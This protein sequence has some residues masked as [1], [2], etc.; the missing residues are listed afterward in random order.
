PADGD[1]GASLYC[2]DIVASGVA[3]PPF[4]LQPT[5]GV[6]S[7]AAPPGGDGAVVAGATGNNVHGDVHAI[8]LTG[9][10]APAR[11]VWA[12]TD[13]GI[14]VSDRSGRVGTFSPANTG[15]ASL[16]PVFVRSHPSNGHVML[17]GCQD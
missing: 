10:V 15:L 13:G 11:Q 8:K 6:S 9:A 3:V 12:A 17:I 16:Q 14:F 4:T 7:A 5:V 1:W 2:F